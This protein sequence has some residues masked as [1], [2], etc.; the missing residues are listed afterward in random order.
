MD[1]AIESSVEADEVGH[2]EP[3]VDVPNRK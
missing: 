2:V 3:D 1:E